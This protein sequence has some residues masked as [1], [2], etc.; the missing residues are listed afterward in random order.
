MAIKGS[1]ASTANKSFK[2]MVKFKYLGTMVTTHNYIH[3]EV[4]STLNLGTLATFQFR[5]FVFPSA[6]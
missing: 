6:I 4:K 1:K 2:N 3:E 5:A